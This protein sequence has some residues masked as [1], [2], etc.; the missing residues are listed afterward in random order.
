MCERDQQIQEL[1][2]KIAKLNENEAK[3]EFEVQELK[4]MIA[5]LEE[6]REQNINNEKKQQMKLETMK[7]EVKRLH[8]IT[9]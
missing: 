7:A 8:L 3:N 9:N 1:N 6:E 5:G 4:K 2:T